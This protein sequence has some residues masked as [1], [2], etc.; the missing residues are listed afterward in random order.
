MTSKKRLGIV[1]LFPLVVSLAGC[2]D[3]KADRAAEA[4]RASQLELAQQLAH[5][6]DFDAALEQVAEVVAASED[7]EQRRALEVQREVE[8]RRDRHAAGEQELDALEKQLDRANELDA[9][10]ETARY[11]SNFATFDDLC[12]RADEL[13]AAHEE[14]RAQESPAPRAAGDEVVDVP[15]DWTTADAA[16]AADE[17]VAQEEFAKARFVLDHVAAADDAAKK[18]REAAV[19]RV[20]EAAR[21]AA[22]PI[23]QQVRDDL[24]AG[25]LLQALAALDEEKLRRFRGT[26]VGAELLDKADDVEDAIDAQIAP[27]L[28]PVP[29]RQHSPTHVARA[30]P[31]EP[32]ATDVARTAPVAPPP[33]GSP[34]VAK[35]TP[36]E[37][38]EP[39]RPPPTPAPKPDAAPSSPSRPSSRPATKAE[40]AALTVLFD[41]VHARLAKGDFPA[42]LE[43]VDHALDTTKDDASIAALVRERERANRPLLLAN[44]VAEL[45]AQRPLSNS[46]TVDLRDG[47]VGRL[48]GSTGTALRVEI[49]S[50]TNEVAPSELTA[51]ALLDVSG[52]TA[53]SSEEWLDRAFVALA[54]QDDKALFASLDRAAS[55]K[56][57]AKLQGSI[58]SL[59]AWQ[60]GLES[61]P[62]RGFARVGE[63]WLTWKERA[64]L[65]LEREVKELLAAA[66]AEKGDSGKSRLKIAELASADPVAVVEALK[67]RRS[68]LHKAFD[69]SPDHEKLAKMRERSVKLQ[70][71]RQFAL[72]LIFDEVKYFYPHT[73]P[74]CPPAKAAEYAIVQAEVDQRVD[75]VRALWGRES[76]EPPKPVVTLSTATAETVRQLGAVRGLLAS[77]GVAPD[78]EELA[79]APVWCLPPT[80]TIHLRNFAIDLAERARLDGDAKVWMLNAALQPKDSG[81]SREELEQVLVTNRYRAMLGRRVLAYNEKL[82]LAARG[83]SDWMARNGVL[84]HFETGD[85]ARES[86]EGRCRVAGYDACAG[87]NCAMGRMG[88]L[89]VLVG[90]CHSSGHHR[91]LLFESHTEMGSGQSGS[92]WTQ[93]FG[94]GLEYKGNLVKD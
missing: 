58:D 64:A 19:A 68:E 47:R 4:A 89:E 75:A 43:Q 56:D 27:S 28:R 39:P 52:R 46:P 1:L 55:S 24:K 77:L 40:S 41:E 57:V 49:E 72:D 65:D 42:A 3:R 7:V 16:S 60:R 53:L 8:A 78:E 88:P 21:V 61:V 74:A 50:T 6:G 37:P 9:R 90:W 13:L 70:A 82:F 83:H 71:A 26:A 5:D 15:P 51:R 29:R 92:F 73:P 84:T 45:L 48:S 23:V 22:D 33:S 14:R 11:R 32:A 86:P 30:K 54:C 35:S 31:A 63:K 81:V 10:D 44:R 87:E 69:A 38:L 59:L 94:G 91:N 66:L 67:S 18:V 79:L 85:P 17:F 34:P 76:E 93:D 80:R 20:D 25:R 2:S 36:P 12:A 62:P